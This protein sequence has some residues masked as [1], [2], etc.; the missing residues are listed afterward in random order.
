MPKK[1]G[2]WK[3]LDVLG[4]NGFLN[5]LIGLKW[6]RERL[7][8]ESEEWREAVDD[9]SW[10]LKQMNGAYAWVAKRA[11]NACRSACFRP[12]LCIS[13]HVFY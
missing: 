3:F 11:P 9:V 12:I 5:V 10:V 8:E 7:D 1:T 4:Q 13:F 2:P 6:W